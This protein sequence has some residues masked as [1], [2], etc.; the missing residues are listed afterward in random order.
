MIKL[1]SLICE[2]I[3]LTTQMFDESLRGAFMHYFDTDDVKILNHDSDSE[4]TTFLHFT[5]DTELSLLYKF[6]KFLVWMRF[7]YYKFPPGQ[8]P[9]MKYQTRT[10]SH[11]P[12]SGGSISGTE[13]TDASKAEWAEMLRLASNMSRLKPTKELLTQKSPLVLWKYGVDVSD[14]EEFVGGSKNQSLPTLQSVVM[15]A[16]KDIDEWL[17]N[18]GGGDNPDESPVIPTPVDTPE[19]VASV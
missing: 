15:A 18:Q 5:I 11:D 8:L 13:Y 3:D 14:S 4:I 1:K 6:H 19:P 2:D 17:S 16:K 9:K 10:P 7:T 12:V